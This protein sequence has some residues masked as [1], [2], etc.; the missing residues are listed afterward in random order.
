MKLSF[1]Y[2]I[3]TNGNA[4]STIVTY[5]KNKIKCKPWLQN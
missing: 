3:K 5:K 1:W 4:L 2:Q